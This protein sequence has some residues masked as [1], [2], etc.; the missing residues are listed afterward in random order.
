VL[1]LEVVEASGSGTLEIVRVIS[2]GAR[3]AGH[4][5][6]V[7]Y[8][9]RPE[10]P[11]DPAA[12]FGDGIEL[13][14]LPWP[15]RGLHWQV[16]SVRALRQLVRSRRPDV[17]H[18]HSSFAGAVGAAAVGRR[19][20]SVYTPHGYSF[21]RT[22]VHAAHRTLFR[23]AERVIARVVDVVAAVSEAEAAVA[24]QELRAP[25]VVTIPNGIRELDVLPTA[26]QREGARVVALGRVGPA[27]S[28][29]TT[30]SI[31]GGLRDV[32]TVEWIG[33]GA[34]ADEAP[35]REA[36]IPISGWLDREDALERLRAATV[37]LRWSAW[38]A[39]P[40]ALLEAMAFDVVV[41]ASDIP[42]NRELLGPAAVCRTPR[43]A[44]GRIRALLRDPHLV[45]AAIDAQRDAR[46]MFGA[47]RMVE[48]WLRLYDS[49]VA[50]RVAGR[51]AVP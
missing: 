41:V 36:G 42:A 34:T 37:L 21:L 3:A 6:I 47:G 5:V 50:G 23:S 9:M 45:S 28:P 12:H 18:L 43:E 49:V 33:G 13:V 10:T 20:P 24:E 39:A 14:A 11:A 4:E 19:A 8:G 1:I 51:A 16:R 29:G 40:V 27:L 26:G 48:G 22:D 30:A 46:R 35:L 2:R 25:R 7:A 31:F 38:D 44:V 17:V 32:A 15:D